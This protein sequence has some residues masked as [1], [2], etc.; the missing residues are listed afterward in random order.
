MHNGNT[1]RLSLNSL[2]FYWVGGLSI[3]PGRALVS[4]FI[5]HKVRDAAALRWLSIDFL[6]YSAEEADLNGIAHVQILAAYRAAD[7]I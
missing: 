4:S 5:N 6:R 2:L 1:T 3:C 7:C